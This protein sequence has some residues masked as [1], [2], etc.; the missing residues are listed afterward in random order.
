MEEKIIQITSGKGPDECERVTFLV[1]QEFVAYLKE[2]NIS[3]EVLEALEGKQE[4]TF[5]S[6]L[7]KVSHNDFSSIKNEWEGS[8]L[9]TAQSPFRK[10][11][12]RKNWFVGLSF[13]EILTQE[14]I[15][16]NEVTYQTMRAS[17]PGGQNVNK[18]ET[19]VRATHIKS[20]ISVRASNSKSQLQNKKNALLLIQHKLAEKEKELKGTHEKEQ[21]LNHHSL[22]RGNPIKIY[23]A[24]MD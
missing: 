16:E 13:H 10:F 22:S 12:K 14:T 8:I 5:L 18:V 2:K 11:H 1:F 3:F 23:K 6:V 7:V 19:A 20:G 4:R 24:K 21:W 17:G 9:W 15:Q